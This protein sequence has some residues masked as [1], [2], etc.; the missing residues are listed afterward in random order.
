MI[1]DVGSQRVACC[2]KK[3]LLG[4][5]LDCTVVDSQRRKEWKVWV[6]KRVETIGMFQKSSFLP[7]F[8]NLEDICTIECSVGKLK[9]CLLWWHSPE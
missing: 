5:L 6:Q 9:N 4:R 3:F 2:K 7:T 8:L 1:C